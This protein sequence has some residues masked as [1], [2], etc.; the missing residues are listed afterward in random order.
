M[1]ALIGKLHVSIFF[2]L[3]VSIQIHAQDSGSD[4][5]YDS[6]ARQ[7]NKPQTDTDRIK[8]LAL[9]VDLAPESGLSTVTE[10]TVDYLRQLVQYNKRAHFMDGAPYE[11][12]LDGYVDWRKGALPEAL[13]DLKKVVELF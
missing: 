4:Y 6:L 1:K 12:L 8:L 9:L 7:S 13:A 5:D 11:V 3:I 10:K 2:L